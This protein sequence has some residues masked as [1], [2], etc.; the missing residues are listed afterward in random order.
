MRAGHTFVF[1]L[2]FGLEVAKHSATFLLGPA[3]ICWDAAQ[4]LSF[5]ESVA[6]GDLLL[7]NHPVNYR[8]PGYPW[9]VGTFVALFENHAMLAIV[10]VQH[11][12]SILSSAVPAIVVRRITGSRSAGLAAY[13][14]CVSCVSRDWFANTLLNETLFTF[15]LTLLW[16]AWFEYLRG[17]SLRGAKWIGLALAA[18]ILVRPIPQLFW[19]PIFLSVGL[20][21]LSPVAKL[22]ISHA[23][24]HCAVIALI[25]IVCLM[26]WSARN[27]SMFGQPYLAKLPAV[28][29]WQVCFQKGAS[30]NLPF[31]N[32]SSTTELKAA[33]KAGKHEF[34]DFYCY[35]VTNSLERAG[36]SEREIDRLVSRLCWAAICEH[37]F[38]F[39]WATLKRAANVW[40]C[41][42]NEYPPW[43]NG[44]TSEHGQQ[45]V[46]RNEKVAQLYEPILR[47]TLSRS[48]RANEFVFFCVTLG[49]WWLLR[50]PNTRVLGCA[51]VLTFA[52][53]TAIT[54]AVEIE[55]YRYRMVL[56][57]AM[58]IAFVAGA[59]SR[60]SSGP[61]PPARS[62]Y[63]RG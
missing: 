2:L 47:Y 31:P 39:G 43:G 49:C 7:L 23:A 25:L 18:A 16:W 14:L 20:C 57:H 29:K 15:C 63:P 44:E 26:P 4:Y 53:F 21:V 13:G 3:P 42:R 8:T 1:L 11:L 6:A 17:P 52:Y 12:L 19:I 62:E 33:L 51:L 55:N 24:A 50:N 37:P 27:F 32:D 10:A 46:W 36:M 60:F 61:K 41:V 35:D 9:F 34:P 56:E 54:S 45:C 30:A 48:L 59:F 28:N 5:G 40:R 38:Q 58:I 22:R